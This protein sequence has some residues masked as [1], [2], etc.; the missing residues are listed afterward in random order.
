MSDLA[1]LRIGVRLHGF[2]PCHAPPKILEEGG[3]LSAV[4]LMTRKKLFFYLFFA[5]R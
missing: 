5:W 1:I 3:G 2:C 4:D